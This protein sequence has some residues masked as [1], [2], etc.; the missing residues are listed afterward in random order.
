MARSIMKGGPTLDART[1][2][3]EREGFEPSIRVS[4]YAGLANRCLQPLGHLSGRVLQVI[5]GESVLQPYEF[6]ACCSLNDRA[7]ASD[8]RFATPR[9]TELRNSPKRL[10][11]RRSAPLLGLFALLFLALPSVRL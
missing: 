6:S 10:L 3:A 7:L 8:F 1:R 9:A 4:T 11:M 5:G 2:R